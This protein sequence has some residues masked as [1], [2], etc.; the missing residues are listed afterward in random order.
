MANAW[1]RFKQFTIE[2]SQ[3][4]MKVGMDGVTLGAWA[5][6]DGARRILDIGTGTG[7]IALM[8]AQRAP[9]AQIDALEIDPAAVAQAQQNVRAS[10][11]A[12]RVRVH[13]CA[14]QAWQAAPYDLIV[15]NPPFFPPGLPSSSL[16]R[17]QARAT[18]TLTHEDLL[19]HALRLLAP[20][21]CLALV[22]PCAVAERC[23][24]T[25]AALGFSVQQQVQLIPCP[26]KAPNRFLWLLSRDK[27]YE[28]CSDL[29]IRTENGEYANTYASMVAPFY[30]KL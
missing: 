4:A 23:R 1:F 22:W 12:D 14:L 13:A 24:P 3:C 28:S 2:Q 15:S 11:W 17:D 27:H 19:Q 29:L 6:V 20:A 7:L 25:V 5:P 18:L 21:G 26:G 8:L 9:A 30:L 10:P 16:A